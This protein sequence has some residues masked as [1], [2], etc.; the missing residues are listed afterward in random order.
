MQGDGLREERP[1]LEAVAVEA[2]YGAVPIV[3]GVSLHVR[4]GEIVTLVGPNGAGKSTLLKAIVGLLPLMSGEVRLNAQRVDHLATQ[5][6]ARIG[7]GYVPQVNDVFG[8]LSVRENLM[9]G[10]YL[11]TRRA[12]QARIDHV[13]GIFP[14]LRRLDGRTAGKLSGGER[15]MLA[16]GRALMAAPT[17]LVLDEPT[18]NLSPELSARVLEE[19]VKGLAEQQVAILLV[20]QKAR[21]AMAI[22]DRTYVMVAGK[23][24]LEGTP[25]ALLDRSEFGDLML[26]QA[27]R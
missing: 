16:L 13:Y 21:R 11:C 5:Q 6:L 3:G 4:H 22:S 8:P 24:E 10:G 14:A 27:A 25:A 20:E 18:A 12:M 7:L 19:H 1:S 2:G 15:K 26:G 23:V 9:L 17:V